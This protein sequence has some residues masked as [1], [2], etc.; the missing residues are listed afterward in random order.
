MKRILMFFVMIF[1]GVAGLDAHAFIKGADPAVGSTLQTSPREVRIWFSE[2]IKAGV[3]TIRV[4]DSSGGEID[5]RDVRLDPSNQKQLRVS[6]PPLGPGTYK[7]VWRVV[8]VDTHVTTGSFKFRMGRR[9]NRQRANA[10]I[11]FRRI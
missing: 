3:S 7:V 9:G 2:K 1:G 4:F 8:S 6:L 5:K 11:D 10:V